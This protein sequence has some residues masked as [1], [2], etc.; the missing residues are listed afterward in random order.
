M[1]LYHY[2]PEMNIK[3][4][5]KDGLLNIFGLI[6]FTTSDK[7]ENTASTMVGRQAR[8]IVKLTNKH[9]YVPD[10]I[11]SNYELMSSFFNPNLIHL[12][13]DVRNWYC[14]DSDVDKK[15]IIKYE[16]LENGEWKEI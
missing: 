3:S 10:M 8:I 16:V 13:S 15:D 9:K 4:I 6:F 2:T 5:K 12:I 14:L 1:Y 11:K 7:G